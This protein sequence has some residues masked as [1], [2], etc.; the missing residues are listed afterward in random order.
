M[1]YR[2]KFRIPSARLPGWD[3]RWAGVYSVT[4][5]VLHRVCCLGTV[6]DGVV[7]LSALGEII[8]E[9]WNQIPL[10]RP[11]ISL[12]EFVVMPDHLHGILVFRE[13]P[14]DTAALP[15][16]RLAPNSLGAIIGQFKSRC[17]KRIWQAGHRDFD[18]QTRFFDQII[19]NE[20][21]LAYFR[22]YIRGNP[23]R[24]KKSSS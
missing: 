18:W 4:I 22:A 8:A 9:E 24:W 13:A 21:A 15:A 5:C 17:T 7:S 6:D 23:L 19:R 2:G 3:Y 10:V 16:S 14:G 1:R 12:D 20:R 11:W